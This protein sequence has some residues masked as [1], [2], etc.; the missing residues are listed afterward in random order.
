MK[1]CILTSVHPPFDPRIFHRQARSLVEAG[2]LVT[3]V[4]PHGQSEETRDG[5]RL[6]GLPNRR[7]RLRRI[8]LWGKLLRIALREKSEVYHFHDPELTLPAVLLR[9]L[10]PARLIYDVHE[11][12]P[13]TILE[14]T[15]IPWPLRRSISFLF[16]LWERTVARL[17]HVI[18]TA[19]DAVASRFSPGHPR[20]VTLYNFPYRANY[21]HLPSRWEERGCPERPVLVYVGAM[22]RV[23]GLFL[24][25]DVVEL[26]VREWGLDVRL[27]L[28]GRIH[29]P[30]ER[31]EFEERIAPGSDLAQRVEWHGVVPHEEVASLIRKSHIGW[32]PFLDRPKFHKN[33]PTKLFEYM[34]CSLPVVASDVRPA[35]RFIGASGS[36]I[37]V[38][39][40]N[41]RAHAEAIARLARNP[42][43]SREM[44]CAG[45][46]AFETDYNWDSEAAKLRELYGS[47]VLSP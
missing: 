26:L 46:H 5:V 11:D 12:N 3:L 2:H 18:V 24:M 33:I 4:A 7:G 6:L 40:E 44:G 31:R 20:V 22:A 36:G 21:P 30:A 42:D 15:W 37:L 10:T 29:Y 1:I 14:K 27:E 16:G 35:R 19:D 39:P 41:P 43:R 25:L 13:D 32:I 47:L 28:A 9:I 45:R 34:A 38:E 8:G 17:F 23:R